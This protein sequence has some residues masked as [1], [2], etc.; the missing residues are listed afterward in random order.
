MWLISML[1]DATRTECALAVG[2]TH[3]STVIYAIKQV[4]DYRTVYADFRATT[5]KLYSDLQTQFSTSVEN[6]ERSLLLLP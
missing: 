4:E 6:D 1:V 2:K 3:H 5:D